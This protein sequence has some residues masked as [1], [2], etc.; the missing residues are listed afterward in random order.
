MSDSISNSSNNIF[1]IDKNTILF[2]INNNKNSL[3]LSS[4]ILSHNKSISE[5]IIKITNLTSNYLAN[6]N[7]KKR[8]LY[9]Y[10][11]IFNN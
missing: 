8:I 3:N 5:C 6:K 2:K 11:I 1:S 9:S 4:S 10:S 7:N